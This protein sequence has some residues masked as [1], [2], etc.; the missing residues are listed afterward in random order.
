M[1]SERGGGADKKKKKKKKVTTA[2]LESAEGWLTPE[3]I[4][5][6]FAETNQSDTEKL[7][8]SA[9]LIFGVC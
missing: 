5:N 9:S 3:F 8:T 6:Q 1:E 2:F 7:Y 4:S